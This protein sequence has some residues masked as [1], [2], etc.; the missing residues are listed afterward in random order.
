M[1]TIDMSALLRGEYT[2]VWHEVIRGHD[3]YR[4]TMHNWVTLYTLAGPTI[5][6]LH[7]NASLT[8]LTDYLY[9]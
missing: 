8:K 1:A 2:V 6:G 9:K 4:V 7:A 3:V 5:S